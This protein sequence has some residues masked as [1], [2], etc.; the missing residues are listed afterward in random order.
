MDG[1]IAK[2][3][4][5]HCA[6]NYRASAFLALYRVRRLGWERGRALDDLASFWKPEPAWQELIDR[7]LGSA[8]A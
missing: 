1:R 4:L 7:I 5:V 8:S 6:L 2:G 3:V